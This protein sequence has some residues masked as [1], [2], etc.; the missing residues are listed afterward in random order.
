MTRP[1]TLVE[2][3][4]QAYGKPDLHFVLEQY[5]TAVVALEIAAAR[6]GRT[7]HV[8]W[9]HAALSRAQEIEW[10]AMRYTQVERWRNAGRGDSHYRDDAPTNPRG[11]PPVAPA[12]APAPRRP[13]PAKLPPLPPGRI[14]PLPAPPRLPSIIVQADNEPEVHS[15][16]EAVFDT[17]RPT[18]PRRHAQW[19]RLVPHARHDLIMRLLFELAVIVLIVWSLWQFRP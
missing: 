19:G 13:P 1:L 11:Y 10:Q 6:L 5:R 12:P 15:H 14:P 4:E 16:R 17:D 18:R 3:I 7:G 8:R 2:L 9:Q